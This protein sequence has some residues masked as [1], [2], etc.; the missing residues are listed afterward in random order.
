MKL[1]IAIIQ[2]EDA[3][4]LTEELNNNGFQVTRLNTVGGFLKKKN[5]TLMIG[6]Q[7]EK[8]DEAL[9]IIRNLCKERQELVTAPIDPTFIDTPVANYATGGV[10]V[11]GATIFILDVED[12]IKY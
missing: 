2:N 9:K 12:F 5:S 7:E 1:L 4:I 10:K 6:T 8:I 11:G 3:Y